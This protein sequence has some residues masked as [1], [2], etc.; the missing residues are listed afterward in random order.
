MSDILSE[1]YRQGFI[2]GMAMNPLFVTTE[3]APSESESSGGEGI[4]SALPTGIYM[5][6]IDGGVISAKKEE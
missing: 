1:D 3:T 5:C 6:V 4:V 2:T